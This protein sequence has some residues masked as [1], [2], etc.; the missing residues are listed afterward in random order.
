MDTRAAFAMLC[1][2]LRRLGFPHFPFLFLLVLSPLRGAAN[3]P[4]NVLILPFSNFSA[5]HNLDWVGESFAVSI[6]QALSGELP[7]VVQPEERDNALRQM[8]VRKYAPLTS[9]SVIE[10]AVNLDA[11]MVVA[12]SVESIPGT[13]GVHDGLRVRA[14]LYNARKLRHI[15]DFDV[16][17]KMDDLSLVQSHLAWQIL[18]ALRPEAASTE[19]EYLAARPPVRLD[20]IERYVRGLIATSYDQKLKLFTAAAR[21]QPDYSAACY[22]LGT[23]Y[24]SRHEFRSAAEWLERVAPADAHFRQALFRLGLARYHTGDFKP[25]VEAFEKLSRA[26]SLSEVLNN[27]GVA[28]LRSGDARAI[29][30]LR[31]AIEG[32]AADPDYSFNAGLALYRKGDFE[33]AI[34]LLESTLTRKPGDEVADRLLG[35]CRR[36]EAARPG[37]VK[38]E[39]LERIKENYDET[40]WLQLK[41][42]IDP[43]GRK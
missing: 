39:A 4:E 5:N 33:A 17:G 12:G 7:F 32:D 9:A 15:K 35:K 24:Y 26:I 36:K 27:L 40:A 6:F 23:L 14:Q 41:A 25:S 43:D 21:L 38:S 20:A 13:N 11:V 8:N 28:Q 29:G 1:S 31:K 19:Q 16:S 34:P 22:E 10:I 42:L 3:P 37:D 2:V 18:A 30:N